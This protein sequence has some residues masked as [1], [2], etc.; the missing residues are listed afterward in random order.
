MMATILYFLDTYT[1]LHLAYSNV[2]TRLLWKDKSNRY[3]FNSRLRYKCSNV[4]R[5]KNLLTIN[6]LELWVWLYFTACETYSTCCI[7]LKL[8]GC[9]LKRKKKHT[10][11]VLRDYFGG[12][13]SFYVIQGK[14]K[15]ILCV[16]TVE[17]LQLT[18]CFLNYWW[19]LAQFPR[20]CFKSINVWLPC[21]CQ[22]V[23]QKGQNNY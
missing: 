20:G 13:F 3:K 7:I 15:S 23:T 9:Q 11:L 16:A 19:T 6:M 18:A 4:F 10:R 14:D 22:R 12:R 8:Y 17:G 2:A 5:W 1:L 21:S